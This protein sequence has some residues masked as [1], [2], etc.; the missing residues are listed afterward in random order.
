[1]EKKNHTKV[2]TRKI[3]KNEEEKLYEELIQKDIDALTREKVIT[4]KNMI[5]WIFLIM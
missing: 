5:S 3:S 2:T 4:L 1:M